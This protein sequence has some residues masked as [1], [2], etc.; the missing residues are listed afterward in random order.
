MKQQDKE[1]R[2]ENV[3]EDAIE[4]IIEKA[5][6]EAKDIGEI[7]SEDEI[8]AMRDEMEKAYRTIENVEKGDSI[9]SIRESLARYVGRA[10]ANKVI[11]NS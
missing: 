1:D 2:L 5:S 11:K 4:A 6:S 9:R 8:M 7:Y 3:R 10:I